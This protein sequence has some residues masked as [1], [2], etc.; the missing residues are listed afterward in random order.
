MNR[1]KKDKSSGGPTRP[2]RS[3]KDMMKFL[4]VAV[5]LLVGVDYFL[6]GGERPYMTKIKKDHLR[7]QL[8]QVK[9]DDLTPAP[10]M[11]LPEDGSEYFEA[12]EDMEE[13]E[14]EKQS[15]LFDG[16][17]K[18]VEPLMSIRRKQEKAEDQKAEMPAPK[19]FAGQKAKIAI[20]ID[21]MGMNVS[22]SLSAVDL[23]SGV[24]LAFLPYAETV[25]AMADKASKEGHEII[26]HTPMEALGDNNGLGPMALKSGMDFAAFTGEFERMAA[27][28]EGYAGVN[29][30]M[31]SLLTQDPEAMGYLMDQ[32]KLR[33]LY[34][35]DS[36]TIHKSV[37]ADMAKTYGIP[38]ATRDVFLDHEETPEFVQGA[39]KKMEATARRK[40]YA[41]AIGH[42]KEVTMKALHEWV[43][44]AEARGF[45]LVPVSEL[46]NGPAMR[47][48]KR[49]EPKLNLDMDAITPAGG[50]SHPQPPQ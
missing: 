14:P 20:V 11:V 26:I 29:N 33:N 3:F 34:F 32:L 41:I 13:A 28:F 8:E 16:Q 50:I 40:G 12:P 23:P 24:T 27:S 2:R 43:K 22:Q 4:I 19:T 46:L 36:R 31:G 25:R 47:V 30:H 37:A 6:W 1:F 38:Y 35:L 17:S 49:E 48:T 7:E 42:P 5:V 9:E 18:A 21:D 39:L 15:L 45:E 44:T 10:E